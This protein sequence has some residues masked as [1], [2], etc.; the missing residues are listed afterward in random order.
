MDIFFGILRFSDLREGVGMKLI[1]G[2][3][4]SLKF[5]AIIGAI[6]LVILAMPAQATF[7]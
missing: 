3:T 7:F 2:M 5:L 4:E 6:A 1:S